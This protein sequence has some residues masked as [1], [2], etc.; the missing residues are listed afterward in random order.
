MKAA[1]LFKI[2]GIAAI[3][4]LTSALV[5]IGS[6]KL[7]LSEIAKAVWSYSERTLVKVDSLYYYV[8]GHRGQVAG[9]TTV[10]KAADKPAIEFGLEEN[11]DAAD[12]LVSTGQ[13][14]DRISLDLAQA[15]S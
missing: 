11:P 13:A 6:R 9:T 7:V 1:Q 5:V 4:V 10:V 8:D 12:K 2:T 14:L 15:S 3:A